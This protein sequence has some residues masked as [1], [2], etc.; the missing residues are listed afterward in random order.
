MTDGQSASSRKD[1][2]I[3]ITNGDE[4]LEFAYEFLRARAMAPTDQHVRKVTSAVARCTGTRMKIANL[5]SFVVG[6][7]EKQDLS[8][9][10]R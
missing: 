2:V 6:L 3:D 9:T 8:D 1:D 10:E 4:V 7:L 5:A